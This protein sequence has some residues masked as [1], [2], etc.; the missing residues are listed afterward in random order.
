M[1]QMPTV[2]FIA[3]ISLFVKWCNFVSAAAEAHELENMLILFPMKKL[4]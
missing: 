1:I 3:Q 4:F 2:D